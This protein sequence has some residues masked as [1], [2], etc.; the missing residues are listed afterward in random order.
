M[1]NSLRVISLLSIVAQTAGAVSVTVS[2]TSDPWLSGMPD[3]STASIYDSAPAQ[4]PVQVAGLSVTGGNIYTFQSLG[5]VSNGPGTPV[6]GP[7]GGVLGSQFGATTH[8][9]DWFVNGPQNGIGDI[10]VPWNSVIGVFLGPGQPDLNTPPGALDFS[11][12]AS[13]DYLTLSPLLQQP[14][15]I[16]DG[17]TSSGVLQ[18]VIAPSGATRLFLGT[19]DSYQWGD[20]TGS[21]Q[22]TITL[23]PEPSAVVLSLLSLAALIRRI[24]S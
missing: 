24:R 7:D 3:G 4:S 16:G 1:K 19:M 12:Q 5:Q 23:V 10:T 9:V 15:F 2:G 8:W 18:Q 17:L 13:L 20:N 22:V 6:D 14:F 11:T 21:F